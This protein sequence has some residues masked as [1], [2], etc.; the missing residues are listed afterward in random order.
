MRLLQIV[1]RQCT[2]YV[3]HGS[4]SETAEE[5]LQHDFILVLNAPEQVREWRAA[6]FRPDRQ[7]RVWPGHM[8]D[9]CRET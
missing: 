3:L 2:I 1:T 5:F 9:T 7:L 8:G 4:P 6:T